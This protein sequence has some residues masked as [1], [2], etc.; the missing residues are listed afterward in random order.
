MVQKDNKMIKSSYLILFVSII[1]LSVFIYK[2]INPSE[3][4]FLSDYEKD[5]LNYFKEVTLN[6]EF[7]ESPRSIIK[8]NKKMLLYISRDNE[9]EKQV[10]RI[11]EVIKEI[12]LLTAKS[13]FEIN[14]TKDKSK[15]NSIIYLGQRDKVEK[16][17]P[18]FFEGVDKEFTG[19]VDI[20]FDLNDYFITKSIIFIDVNQPINI[21]LS[22]ILEELSQSIG[23]PAGS[24]IYPNSIF[25]ENQVIEGRLN[26][27][28]SQ[29]D[30]DVIKL[31][32]HPKMRAGLNNFHITNVYKRILKSEGS[33]YFGGN[34]DF[35]EIKS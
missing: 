22:T 13:G 25:Y 3:K 2:I 26:Q 18:D 7:G 11:N 33:S 28:L 24:E 6:S 21:Q 34:N 4:V 12:N 10:K 31:L 9:Y 14:I 35:V 17:N 8:W 29:I 1:C 30:K 5:L 32:Y 27:N 15:C 19:L 20:E 16:E 23:I